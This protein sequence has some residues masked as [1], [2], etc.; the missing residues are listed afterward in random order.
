MG[1][2]LSTM[3]NSEDS[4]TEKVKLDTLDNAEPEE[5]AFIGQ[6][7]LSVIDG[8]GKDDRYFDQIKFTYSY[9]EF[10]QYVRKATTGTCVFRVGSP[11]NGSHGPF[12]QVAMGS[13]YLQKGYFPNLPSEGSWWLPENFPDKTI[14]WTECDFP[15]EYSHAVTDDDIS[16]SDLWL[17]MGAVVKEP[18]LKRLSDSRALLCFIIAEAARFEYIELAFQLTING[19]RYIRMDY[20]L[21]LTHM[22]K[23]LGFGRPVT[24]EAVDKSNLSDNAK[25]YFQ[26]LRSESRL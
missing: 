4:N 21:E 12:V 9:S 26:G 3:R 1:V 13:L 5:P 11:Q 25:A 23:D 22:W 19:T 16:S 18:D 24:Y 17:K 14:K 10:I 6:W 20:I 8:K 7:V 15:A 2:C